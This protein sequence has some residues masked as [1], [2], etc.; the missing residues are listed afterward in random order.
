MTN[1]TPGPE[2]DATYGLDFSKFDLVAMR[3]PVPMPWGGWCEREFFRTLSCHWIDYPLPQRRLPLAEG[4]RRIHKKMAKAN[5]MLKY[6][7]RHQRQLRN[8]IY[9]IRLGS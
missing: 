5:R 6:R 2:L 8:T 9:R 3:D 1:I 4:I 7:R